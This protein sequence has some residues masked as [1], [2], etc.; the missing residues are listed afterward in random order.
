MLQYIVAK[1][2]SPARVIIGAMCY[3]I[4]TNCPGSL[5]IMCFS[6]V[7]TMSLSVSMKM[8]MQKTESKLTDLG[9]FLA[10]NAT[11]EKR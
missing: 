4:V 1:T 2:T 6:R 8:Q 3:N 11:E 7:V 9:T 10:S 5:F